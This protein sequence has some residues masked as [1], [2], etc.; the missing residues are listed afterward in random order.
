[1]KDSLGSQWVVVGVG[2]AVD[3]SRRWNLQIG[4]VKAYMLSF[5]PISHKCSYFSKRHHTLN[6]H[7]LLGC[8]YFS[9]HSLLGLNFNCFCFISPLKKVRKPKNRRSRNSCTVKVGVVGKDSMYALVGATTWF[10][11]GIT[12]YHPLRS[13][14]VPNWM[15]HGSYKVFVVMWYKDLLIHCRAVL[16]AYRPLLMSSKAILTTFVGF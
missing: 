4:A 5:S 14:L 6:A 10:G 1:M 16:M 12:C 13:L 9:T 11:G 3:G 2:A 15:S 7:Q 8:S